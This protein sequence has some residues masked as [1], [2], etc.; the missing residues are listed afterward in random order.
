MLKRQPCSLQIGV[1]CQPGSV[2]A[3]LEPGW[4]NSIPS[5][6][7]KLTVVLYHWPQPLLRGWLYPTSGSCSSYLYIITSHTTAMF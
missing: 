6:L 1:K 7:Q 2:R 5:V 4:L 3:A